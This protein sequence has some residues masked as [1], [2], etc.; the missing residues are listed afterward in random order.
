MAFGPAMRMKV[1]QKDGASELVVE[2]APLTSAAMGEFVQEEGALQSFAVTRFLGRRLSPVV[3]DEMEW[4][5][6][7][8]KDRESVAEPSSAIQV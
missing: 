1:P 6:K 3:E 8:R 2:L 4:F 7:T 5:E